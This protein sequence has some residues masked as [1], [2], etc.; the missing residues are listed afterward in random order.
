[1]GVEENLEK[2]KL[3]SLYSLDDLTNMGLQFLEV[4]NGFKVF[5][6][7]EDAHNYGFFPT[8][9]GLKYVYGIAK[10]DYSIFPLIKEESQV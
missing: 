7:K 6:R 5:T 1:M 9:E 4:I 10:N 2:P 3:G 8:D